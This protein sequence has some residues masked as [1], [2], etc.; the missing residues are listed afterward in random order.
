[1]LVE[2]IQ[3]DGN[4]LSGRGIADRVKID[5]KICEFVWGIRYL[6]YAKK[7]EFHACEVVEMYYQSPDLKP[8]LV[9]RPKSLSQYTKLEE[10]DAQQDDKYVIFRSLD[11]YQELMKTLNWKYLA[12]LISGSAYFGM[13]KMIDALNVDLKSADS[14]SDILEARQKARRNLAEEPFKS[15]IEE[16]IASINHIKYRRTP[17]SL[18]LRLI[19][20][21]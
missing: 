1:M 4:D 18:I 11:T 10:I 2:L 16:A 9:S 7:P 13:F 21:K 5:G 17:W 20:W 12:G 19:G 14:I 8:W 15:N 6:I 3:N